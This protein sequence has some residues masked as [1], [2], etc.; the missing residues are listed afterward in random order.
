MQVFRVLVQRGRAVREE[1]LVNERVDKCGTSATRGACG[2]L[3]LCACTS[4]KR[5]SGVGSQWT[6]NNESR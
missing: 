1:G 4:T 6:E 2:G 3:A 5:R